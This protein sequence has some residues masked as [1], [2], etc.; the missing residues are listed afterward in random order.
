MPCYN[1]ALFVGAA[2]SSVRGQTFAD[3]ELVII[4]DGSKDESAEIVAS[5][6][7]E[8][9][10][11]R[12]LRNERNLGLSATRN[13]ALDE[14]RGEFVAW[15]DSDDVAVATRLR[16]QLNYFD[17]NPEFGLLG[18]WVAELDA[19]GFLTGRRWVLNAPPDDFAP[20]TLFRSYC[21]QSAMMVRREALGNARYDKS[22]G[23]GE[24]YEFH[25]RVSESTRCWNLPKVL[26]HYRCH[27]TNVSLS[28]RGDHT[29][30]RRIF[31]ARLARLGVEPSEEELD[32]HQSLFNVETR[33]RTDL[34][35][36]ET[37]LRRLLEANRV[38]RTYPARPFA[39][40][41]VKQL[42]YAAWAAGIPLPSRASRVLRSEV[43]REAGL[44]ARDFASI[45]WET[46]EKRRLGGR[47]GA[48][49]TG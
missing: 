20:T 27:Q 21:W 13:R 49:H 38:A 25:A 1:G 33:G 39:R 19:G 22:Y 48:P 10:R 2:I 12:L 18:S 30:L 6:A 26:C 35:A 37:W 31:R 46:I 4:D 36:I 7:R 34:A 5:H 47:P 32:L 9:S 3:F 40:V 8:D 16:E 28:G 15:L 44:S 11:I 24:D 45:V 43:L 42:L 29:P 23:V 14:A 17:D 41:V